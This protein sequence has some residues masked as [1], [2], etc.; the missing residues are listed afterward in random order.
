MTIKLSNTL[1]GKKEEFNPISDHSVKMYVCGVTPYDKVH[2]GHARAYVTF[3]VIR[4]HLELSGYKVKFI[5]NFTDVDDKI[6]NRAKEN[7]SSPL[8][9]SRKFIED[10]FTQMHKLNIKDADAYPKV[11]ETIPQIIKFVNTLIKKGFAYKLGSDVYFSVRKFPGYGKLSKR[12]L[13][14]LKSG[15][16]VA[17]DEGKKDPLDF[18]LWKGSKAD[19]PTEVSWDS[20][21]GKGRP[22]WHIE[23]SVMST[24]ALGETIDIHGGGQDL[25][26]PHHENEI[27][28]SEALTGKLFS[29]YWVHNG[30]VTIN[31]EKMSKSLGNFFT[32]EDIY[33]KFDPRTVRYFLLSQ[34]YKSPLDFSDDRLIEAEKALKGLDEAWRL[35]LL[36]HKDEPS[37]NKTEQKDKSDDFIS[38]FR[39]ALDDDFNTEKALAVL[40]SF[41]TQIMIFLSESRTKPSLD[42][43]IYQT[44]FKMML[45]GYLGI[46]LVK[47]DAVPDEII[48]LINQR[49]EARKNKD[50]KAA[51]EFRKKLDDLGYKIM[52]GPK[53]SFA[54]KK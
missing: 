52:D 6:I 24:E 36:N 26:F 37:E 48:S 1:S 32:L 3:D 49:N 8:A 31:K 19:D 35:M 53:G 38:K 40:H 46:E 20:P 13:D 30:F 41:K 10:Y 22:G 43:G 42:T 47:Y 5:Q 23:C 2:L 14:D 27:A 4:R 45:E 34:H 18:A 15:A 51:D 12:T 16:R 28:Q 33:K 11:T 9:L 25:I 17:V 50:F 7:G 54:V 39:A 21:W 29:K 44:T